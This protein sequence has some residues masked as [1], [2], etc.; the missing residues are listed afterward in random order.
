MAASLAR[1]VV[2]DSDKLYDDLTCEEESAMKEHIRKVVAPSLRRQA[3]R[4]R[5]R[6][7]R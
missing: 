7:R 6:R 5:R 1:D 4:I 3:E 2:Y